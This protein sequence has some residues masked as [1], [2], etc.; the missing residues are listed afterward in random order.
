MV[1]RKSSDLELKSRN[2]RRF[3]RFLEEMS[4]LMANYIDLDFRDLSMMLHD[5]LEDLS[6]AE[7]KVSSL[8]SSNPNKHFLVGVLPRLFVD[9]SLFPTNDDIAQFALSVMDVKIPRYNKKS[10]YEL[11]G[12]VLCQT[13]DLN[14]IRL[15]KLVKALAVL[16]EGDDRAKKLIKERKEQSFGWNAIIQEL[17]E[18]KI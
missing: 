1:R 11:I 16:A 14:D 4:W 9:K 6:K 17:A 7:E 13:N 2:L 10:K 5:R 18:K 15:N 3:A 12:H 8:V